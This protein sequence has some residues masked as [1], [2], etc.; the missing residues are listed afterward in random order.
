MTDGHWHVGN[1]GT[2]PNV[3]IARSYAVGATWRIRLNML[4]VQWTAVVFYLLT[5][6]GVLNIQ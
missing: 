2:R 1:D 5:L 4:S 6:L 3:M